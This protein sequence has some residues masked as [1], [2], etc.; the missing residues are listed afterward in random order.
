MRTKVIES[1]CT[2]EISESTLRSLLKHIDSYK[3]SYQ[4]RKEFEHT[5][6]A[7]SFEDGVLGDV[8]FSIN[9]DVDGTQ[10]EESIYLTLPAIYDDNI[11]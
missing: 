7:Y 5:I 6:N 9:I 1:K 11:E 2:I 3:E 10:K 8:E 4:Y